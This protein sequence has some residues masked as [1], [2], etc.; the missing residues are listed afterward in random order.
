MVAVALYSAE[1]K[2]H[3]T[4]ALAAVT[5]NRARIRMKPAIKT[6]DLK[7]PSR[8]PDLVDWSEEGGSPPLCSADEFRRG[9]MMLDGLV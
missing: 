5:K 4:A 6:G 3:P 2:D 7:N 1:P 9:P 8:Q